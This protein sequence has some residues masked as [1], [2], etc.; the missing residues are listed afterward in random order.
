M[1]F[2]NPALWLLLC[3]L[4]LRESFYPPRVSDSSWLTGQS[5]LQTVWKREGK[6]P[7]LIK[8]A[9]NVFSKANYNPLSGNWPGH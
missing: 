2:Q 5:M 3:L 1:L 6:T 8:A 4:I 7:Y 9:G